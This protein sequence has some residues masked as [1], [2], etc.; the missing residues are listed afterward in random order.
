[1]TILYL[2]YIVIAVN[3]NPIPNQDISSVREYQIR[4]YLR[5]GWNG[6]IGILLNLLVDV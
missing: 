6:F 5:N 3:A 4:T 1:M 2:F